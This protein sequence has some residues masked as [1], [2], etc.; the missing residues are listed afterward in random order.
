MWISRA[1]ACARMCVVWLAC[2]PSLARATTMVVMDPSQ[3]AEESDALIDAVVGA[4][5]VVQTERMV[6][7]DTEL[8][9]RDVLGGSAPERLVVRQAGGELEGRTVFID[10]DAKLLEGERVAAFVREREGRWYLTALGQSVWHVDARERLEQDLLSEH[11]MERDRTGR[12]VP[13]T[14]SPVAFDTLADLAEAA[15]GLRFG[16]AL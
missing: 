2:A 3:Q 8:W 5:V 1:R 15:Q 11:L 7:T 13:A 16:G 10:G 14:S 9:V 4:S 12:V 6:Y